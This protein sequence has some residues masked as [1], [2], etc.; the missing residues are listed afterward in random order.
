MKMPQKCPKCGVSLADPNPRI[1][2]G[3]RDQFSL[4]MMDKDEFECPVCR[5][6]WP[7]PGKAAR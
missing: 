4:V 6:T 2:A 7:R 5:H 3:K 1:P